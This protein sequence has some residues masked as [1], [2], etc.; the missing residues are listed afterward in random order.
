M[1]SQKQLGNLGENLALKYLIKNKYNILN[2]NYV[3]K[4]GEVDV[5]AFDNTTQEI[6]FVEV[7]TRT[8]LNYGWPEESVGE[9]KKQRMDKTAQKYLEDKKYSISQNYYADY[10]R[11]AP[12]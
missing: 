4:G 2:H 11:I 9:K 12:N 3:I 10:Y 1:S 8:S 5:I 6:V 7:K